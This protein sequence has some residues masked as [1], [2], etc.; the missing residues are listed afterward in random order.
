MKY[1]MD[2]AKLSNELM[3]LDGRHLRKK[4]QQGSIWRHFENPPEIEDITFEAEETKLQNKIAALKTL[5]KCNE[6]FKMKNMARKTILHVP[7]FDRRP[8]P[9]ATSYRSVSR[10]RSDFSKAGAP[11]LFISN[12]PCPIFPKHVSRN[13]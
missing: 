3:V 9:R 4:M 10:R 7:V 8:H 13:Y 5:E 12:I 2:K 6:V 1:A 11:N